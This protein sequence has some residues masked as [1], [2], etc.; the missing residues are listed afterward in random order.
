[1]AHVYKITSPTNKIYVGSTFNIKDR[2]SKYRALQC[3]SQRKLYASFLKHG[4]Q[5]HCFEIIEECEKSEARAIELK[6]GKYYDV[7]GEKGLNCVLPK[8]GEIACERSQETRR[9]MSESQK[10]RKHTEETR[11]RRSI[12]LKGRPSH[13]KNKK[14]TP[15][16]KEKMSQQGLKNKYNKGGYKLSKEFRD[17]TSERLKG[18]K[19]S[20]GFKHTEETCKKRREIGKNGN[21]IG[22]AL[23]NKPTIDLETGIVF[24]SLKDAYFQ[25][26]ALNN[27]WK[28]GYLTN[29]LSGYKRNQTSL[30]YI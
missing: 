19:H 9:L 13:M 26:P 15:E 8:V 18:N 11:K 21:H 4:V 25:L 29:M 17:K 20:L 3:V 1:M 10:G 2:F 27:R 22:L 6:Y 7:L 5:N 14:H 16:T 30:I 24:D 28:Y 12:S 23:R